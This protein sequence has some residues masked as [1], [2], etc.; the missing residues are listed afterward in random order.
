MTPGVTTKL[1]GADRSYWT[2]AKSDIRASAHETPTYLILSGEH[3][4]HIYENCSSFKS[5][6]NQSWLWISFLFLSVCL[7]SFHTSLLCELLLQPAGALVSSS[8][9]HQ[10]QEQTRSPLSTCWLGQWTAERSRGQ[11]RKPSLLHTCGQM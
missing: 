1:L 4:G 5:F 11:S 6:L 10:A 2:L 8:A 9:L 7:Y 3:F